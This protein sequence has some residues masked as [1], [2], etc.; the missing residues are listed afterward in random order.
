M[1]SIDIKNDWKLLTVL[2]GFNDICLGCSDKIRF[3]TPDD[4]ESNLRDTLEQVRQDIPRVFVSVVEIFNLSLVYELSK[5]SEYCKT[6]HSVLSIECIC[7]FDPTN[8]GEK[9]R[10][11][12]DNL[13]AQYNE[14]IRKVAEEYGQMKYNDFAVVVQPGLKDATSDMLPFD[15]LSTVR[16]TL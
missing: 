12:A 9:L 3:L 11:D 7:L 2:A 14:R 1:P 4:F 15:I 8:A 5:Q 10:K 13:V 16:M 6:F